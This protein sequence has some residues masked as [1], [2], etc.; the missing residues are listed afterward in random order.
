MQREGKHV[1]FEAIEQEAQ[2]QLCLRVQQIEREILSLEGGRF[3]A[4]VAISTG[5][6]ILFA[7]LVNLH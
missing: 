5:W 2:D 4:C 7:R 3:D 1:T 6:P